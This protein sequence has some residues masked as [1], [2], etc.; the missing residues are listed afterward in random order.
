MYVRIADFS[1]AV[2]S[3]RDAAAASEIF[4]KIIIGQKRSAYMRMYLAYYGQK[5]PRIILASGNKNSKASFKPHDRF[6]SL[7]FLLCKSEVRVRK[8]KTRSIN[9][10]THHH[11]LV[12][13]H[14]PVPHQERLHKIHGRYP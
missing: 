6:K 8:F 10:F 11:P 12:R 7:S 13:H 5:Q 9:K 2:S 14:D 3:D 4:K 1:L